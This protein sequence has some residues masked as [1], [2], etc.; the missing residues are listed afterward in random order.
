MK[1]LLIEYQYCDG[2]HSCEMACKAEHGWDPDKWGIMLAQI[3]PFQIGE[4]KWN[5]DYVPVPTDMC[6]LC[7]DRLELG[8]L[9]T[10]VHHC[11]SQV[12]HYSDVE[13]LAKRAAVT[14]KTV[15]FS[16]DR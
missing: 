9:P 4:G 15:L 16:L 5:Y 7:A 10:C 14:D 6:D 11:Q 2:C 13:E 12:M 1:G 8:K 3:G